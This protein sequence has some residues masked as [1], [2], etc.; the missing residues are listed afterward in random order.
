MASAVPLALVVPLIACQVTPGSPPTESVSGYVEQLLDSAS[1]L[2]AAARENLG[3]AAAALKLSNDLFQTLIPGADSIRPVVTEII[4]AATVLVSFLSP[5]FPVLAVTG[6]VG[7]GIQIGLAV[8][9]ALIAAIP[10]AAPPVPA[11]LRRAAVTRG[12]SS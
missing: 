11:A 5:F 2:P 4:K 9:T 1:Q 6:P 8:L 12:R 7:M 10:M 3:K